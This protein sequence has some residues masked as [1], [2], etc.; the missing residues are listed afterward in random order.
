MDLV[1]FLG[2]ISAVH[3]DHLNEADTRAIIIDPMLERLGWTAGTIKR[4]PYA[5]WTDSRGFI[6]YLLL[7]DG[8]R[9][10]LSKRNVWVVRSTFQTPF[11]NNELQRIGSL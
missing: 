6:D 9:P 11:G 2:S 1:D 7:A 3:L 5:G 10:L 4:E 8:D